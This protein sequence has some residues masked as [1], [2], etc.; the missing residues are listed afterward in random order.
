MNQHKL[1]K[2]L[3]SILFLLACGSVAL[4]QQTSLTGR[5]TDS[6]EAVIA[7]ASVKVMNLDTG[8][9]RQVQTNGEG[10]F[11][12]PF[13]QPGNYRVTVEANGFKTTARDGLQLT[14]DQV[15]RA[16]FALEPGELS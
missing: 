4:A 3:A 7:G 11:T 13:L 16:D 10:F 15:A 1:Q 14:L 9:N 5:V 8:I 12:V 2:A 6:K